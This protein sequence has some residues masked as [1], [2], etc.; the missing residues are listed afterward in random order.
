M[1]WNHQLLTSGY[2]A[3]SAWNIVVVYIR[4]WRAVPQLIFSSIKA[5]V[6]LMA[7]AVAEILWLMWYAKIIG[8]TSTV[9]PPGASSKP[10]MHQYGSGRTV[11]PSPADVV[12]TWCMGIGR[13]WH[14]TCMHTHN[15]CAKSYSWWYKVWLG[16]CHAC[17]CRGWISCAMFYT[18]ISHPLNTLVAVQESR[19]QD[20]RLNQLLSP[21]LSV[22]PAHW[23]SCS[24]FVLVF[25]L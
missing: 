21:S 1:C 11:R 2:S 9:C 25:I 10:V 16:W 5:F 3:Y 19:E 14:I 7:A 22:K 20:T 23:A 17:V 24:C 6:P 4:I 13:R 18:I 15:R 8:S 12:G